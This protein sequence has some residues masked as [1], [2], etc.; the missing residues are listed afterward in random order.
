MK[1]W[2]L[3]LIGAYVS[4]AALV[5]A[6]LAAASPKFL[7]YEG[8]NAIRDGQGGDKKT[9]DGVDFWFDGDPPHRYQV[10]GLITDRRRENGLVGA[11]RMHGLDPDI[12]KTAKAAGGDA[13]IVTDEGSD[14]IGEAGFG[15]A[16]ASGNSSSGGFGSYRARAS[17]SYLSRQVREHSSRYVVVRYLPDPPASPGPAV[18]SPP[19]P[20]A[21]PK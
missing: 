6:G 10:L 20:V 5:V 2:L 3:L 16:V 11:I 14:V 19:A 21:P 1:Y 9:V 13:V 12:A 17:G 8:K 18:A 7:V 15:S 4:G